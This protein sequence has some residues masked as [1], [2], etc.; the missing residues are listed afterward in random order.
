MKKKNPSHSCPPTMSDSFAFVFMDGLLTILNTS[1]DG[2]TSHA[3]R[4]V[5]AYYIVASGSAG[6]KY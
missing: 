5:R 6:R 4:P 2:Q 3:M 1:A